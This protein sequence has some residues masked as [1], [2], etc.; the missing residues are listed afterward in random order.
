MG[1]DTDLD[2]AMRVAT[3]QVIDFLVTEKH[4]TPAD[5]YALAS[6][7][8]DFHVAEAVDLTQVVVGKIPKHVFR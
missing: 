3:Q 8:C 4:L 7:A 2:R 6:I 5:A 1:I